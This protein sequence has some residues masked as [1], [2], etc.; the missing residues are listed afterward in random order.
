M[1]IND[2]GGGDMSSFMYVG[3]Q[4]RQRDTMAK[5]KVIGVGGGRW[6]CC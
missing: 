2:N 1:T 4:T 3:A 6:K 5:I